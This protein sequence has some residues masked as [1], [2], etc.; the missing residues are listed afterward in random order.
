[1]EIYLKIP[2]ISIFIYLFFLVL[3]HDFVIYIDFSNVAASDTA[4]D[5]VTN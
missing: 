5:D 1:L 4:N 3:N 2:L